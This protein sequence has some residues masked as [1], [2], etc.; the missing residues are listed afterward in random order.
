MPPSVMD[1]EKI[2]MDQELFMN[3]TTYA[4]WHF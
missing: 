3:L 1:W 4:N 2:R